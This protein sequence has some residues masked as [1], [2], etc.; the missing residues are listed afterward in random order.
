MLSVDNT[1]EHILLGL[2]SKINAS[3]D[4]FL[5]PF[6]GDPITWPLRNRANAL[7]FFKGRL[8][9]EGRRFRDQA[10]RCDDCR[11]GEHVIQR[12]TQCTEP[13]SPLSID[14]V[15]SMAPDA[16]NAF[17]DGSVI[18]PSSA[19]PVGSFGVWVPGRGSYLPAESE[20]TFTKVIDWPARKHC[21][22]NEAS[23]EG[24]TKWIPEASLAQRLG[25]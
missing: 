16:P 2:P 10:I 15:D 6:I 14:A 21:E 13:P 4:E 9:E 18:G 11:L 3:L 8:S 22:S 7:L 12:A 19:A 17:S 23:P 20:L 25:C 24:R 5:I 1:P